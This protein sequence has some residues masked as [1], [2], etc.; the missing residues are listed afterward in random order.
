[1]LQGPQGESAS[2]TREGRAKGL[3]RVLGEK[4]AFMGIAFGRVREGPDRS[5]EDRGGQRVTFGKTT[6]LKLERLQ[7]GSSPERV[8]VLASTGQLWSGGHLLRDRNGPPERPRDPLRRCAQVGRSGE[9][10]A[11]RLRSSG[12]WFGSTPR[13]TGRP[14]AASTENWADEM[15]AMTGRAAISGVS[16]SGTLA[17]PAHVNY[18][19]PCGSSI[20]Q[21][22]NASGGDPACSRAC[23]S[24]PRPVLGVYASSSSGAI[25]AAAHPP[26]CTLS[27][28]S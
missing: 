24:P 2:V 25:R 12:A 18:R 22:R 10:A 13:S 15:R 28:R 21:G 27:R 8:Q 20:T 11:H 16:R 17:D 4:G 1:M 19:V 7:Q 26:T 3:I 14:V 9:R 23:V 6:M 5:R